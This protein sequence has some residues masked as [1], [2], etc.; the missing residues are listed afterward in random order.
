MKLETINKH[1]YIYKYIHTVTYT[2]QYLIN[3]Q[4]VLISASNR[5][6]SILLVDEEV[7]LLMAEILHHEGWWLSLYLWGFIHPRWCRISSINSTNNSGR[8]S[9]LSTFN[10]T[11]LIR[12][13]GICNSARHS[14]VGG[15]TNPSEKYARQHG[16]SS[17]G[18]GENKKCL[19]P[20]AS[21]ICSMALL[22]Y[23]WVTNISHL[24]KRKMS[25]LKIAFFTGYVIPQEGFQF[26]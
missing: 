7:V 11:P 12:D 19:K 10:T 17:P 2:I 26:S 20:P 5:S 23:L 14:L 6:K 9:Q 4:E 18:R 22:G 13:S 8:L 15:W 3:Y 1:I 16:E 25:H 21:S 24:W